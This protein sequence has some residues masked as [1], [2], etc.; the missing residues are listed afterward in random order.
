MSKMSKIVFVAFTQHCIQSTVTHLTQ[1]YVICIQGLSPLPGGKATVFEPTRVIAGKT[2]SQSPILKNEGVLSNLV[3][4]RYLQTK[5]YP[6]Y[7][8]QTACLV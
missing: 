2:H 6:P 7:P 5:L 4:L 8:K 3:I 1:Y